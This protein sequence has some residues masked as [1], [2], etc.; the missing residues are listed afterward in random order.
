MTKVATGLSPS[1]QVLVFTSNQHKLAPQNEI[2]RYISL[3][4]PV[5]ITDFAKIKNIP[6]FFLR[7]S[8]S[9]YVILFYAKYDGELGSILKNLTARASL[10][11]RAKCLVINFYGDKGEETFRTVG[12][13]AWKEKFLDFTIINVN[14]NFPRSVP[15][16]GYYNP[17]ESRYYNKDLHKAESIFPYKL[18]DT[19]HYE[20]IVKGI[21]AKQLLH[22]WP[23]F[24]SNRRVL[25]IT[26]LNKFKFIL[27]NE[28]NKKGQANMEFIEKFT[29]G[30]YGLPKL[31]MYSRG[32]DK[33]I[34]VVPVIRVSMFG[35]YYLVVSYFGI[36]AMFLV[37]AAML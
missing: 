28:K 27:K 1:H 16:I 18:I 8:V 13:E 32:C 21:S 37:I 15:T 17:F 4:K 11:T 6:R 35:N 36:I 30:T 29:S 9:I 23:N 25:V 14:M 22:E 26:A 34:A 33:V 31:Q 19:H 3:K 12:E 20:F 10:V 7:R 5:I 2:I 24:T